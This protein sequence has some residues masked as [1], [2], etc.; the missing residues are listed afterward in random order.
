MWQK[1]Q[2]SEKRFRLLVESSPDA[3]FVQSQDHFVYVNPAAIRL[4]AYAMSGDKETFLQAGMDDYLAK[5]VSKEELMHV[6]SRNVS[7]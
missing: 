7:E 5:P 1:L 6:I 3:I 2:D 4:T